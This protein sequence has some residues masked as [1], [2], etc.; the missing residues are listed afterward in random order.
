MYWGRSYGINEPTTADGVMDIV[1]SEFD[2]GSTQW[3][4]RAS[5]VVVTRK[6]LAPD[7]VIT[8]VN[9]SGLTVATVGTFADGLSLLAVLPDGNPVLLPESDD[10]YPSAVNNRGQVVAQQQERGYPERGS[11]AMW[12]IAEDGTVDG[13]IHLGTFRP[14]DINDEGVMAGLQDSVAAI[15]SFETNTFGE[16]ELVVTKLPGLSAGNLGVATALNNWGQV[17]GYSTDLRLDTGTFR[18]FLWDPDFGLF[19]LGSLGGTD[20]KALDINDRGQIVGFSYNASKPFNELRAFLW[21]HGKM[22]DLNGKVAANNNR[23]LQSADAI[24]DFG[25]IVG[26]MYTVSGKTTTQK[27]FLLTPNR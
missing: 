18:P 14:L 27:S 6:D 24:N 3:K 20:G 25:H 8:A 15:A 23:T 19:A 13:P 16:I 22:A 26:S 7:I 17:V 10:Y 21:E 4:A 11:G 1:G 5:G 2:K 12:T 9:D